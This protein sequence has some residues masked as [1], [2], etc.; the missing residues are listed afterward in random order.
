MLQPNTKSIF[1]LLLKEKIEK[2]FQINYF[3]FTKQ[4]FW[5][6]DDCEFKFVDLDS[7]KEIREELEETIFKFGK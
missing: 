2:L 3:Y 1:W 4:K 6:F 5:V 7:R